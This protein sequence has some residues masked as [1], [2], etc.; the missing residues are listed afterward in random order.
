M[1]SPTVVKHCRQRVVAERRQGDCFHHVKASG[2]FPPGTVLS[3]CSFDGHRRGKMSSKRPR[4]AVTVNGAYEFDG[5]QDI[6]GISVIRMGDPREC[7]VDETHG[8]SPVKAQLPFPILQ[9]PK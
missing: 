3:G 9:A 4:K 7:L 5:S 2:E 1:S 6:F 8:E